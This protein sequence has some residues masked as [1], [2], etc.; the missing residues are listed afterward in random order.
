MSLFCASKPIR[1]LLVLFR[2]LN[3][4]LEQPRWFG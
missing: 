1:R 2:Q 4:A 3:G